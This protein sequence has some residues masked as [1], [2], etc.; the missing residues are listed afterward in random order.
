MLL[1]LFYCFVAVTTI[2]VLFYFSFFNFLFSSDTSSSLSQITSPV[3]LIIYAKNNAED[4]RKFLP[5]FLNQDH[6]S[7]EL[8]LINDASYDDT[9][10]VMEEFQSKDPRIVLVNVERNERFWG[11]KKYALT[12]GIK[13]ASFDKLIT[14]DANCYPASTHWLQQVANGFQ[15]G[16]SL[17]LGYGAYNM[18]KNSFLNIFIRFEN[19]QNA[20]KYFSAA[21]NF[22]AYKGVS[23]N[24][25]YTAHAFY[26]N[27]GFVDHMNIPLS[28]DHLFV[29][30]IANKN[31]T[32]LIYKE[33]SFTYTQA[34]SS[35]KSWFAE[36][37]NQISVF[38]FYKKSEIFK[39]AVFNASQF[40][41]W[42][43]SIL[44]F[45]FYDWCW[46]LL[47]FLIRTAVLYITYAKA[48]SVFKEKQ[49]LWGLV[50]QDF[51]W[52]FLRMFIFIFYKFSKPLYRK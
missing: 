40:L 20:I 31:N 16:K 17:I 23:R 3:S 14:I 22:K 18:V 13:K 29:N 30:Q 47:I 28:D 25:A 51:L 43:F 19:L 10:E 45:C 26:E 52:V 9:L 4:L 7:F 1:T 38:S 35:W 15:P 34:T 12:L 8:V 2:N 24:L 46:I 36:K 49:L 27:R 44:L 42:L 6:P 5:L 11:N 21:K 39:L 33:K 32:S 37:R 50:F 48:T 41:F